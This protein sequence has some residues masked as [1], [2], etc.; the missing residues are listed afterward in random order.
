M[1]SNIVIDLENLKGRDYLKDR[2]IDGMI[3]LKWMLKKKVGKL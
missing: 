1:W 3:I 2:C